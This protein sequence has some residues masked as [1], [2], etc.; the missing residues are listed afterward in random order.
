VLLLV[1]QVLIELPS[2]KSLHLCLTTSELLGSQ[3]QLG[4]LTS[5][6]ELIS[7]RCLEVDKRDVR[8]PNLRRLA[9]SNLHSVEPLLALA[10][11]WDRG[12][13][14]TVCLVVQ[15]S[16][17]CRCAMRTALCLSHAILRSSDEHIVDVLS[18][19]VRDASGWII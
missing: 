7:S 8:P 9:V 12:V 11:M 6:T 17:C 15:C 19:R 5:L 13:L 18:L 4:A 10:C 3:L 16:R 2:L 14:V 1:L